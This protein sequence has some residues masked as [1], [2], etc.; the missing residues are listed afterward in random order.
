MVF[1]YKG[2]PLPFGPKLAHNIFHQIQRVKENKPCIIVVDGGLGLGKTTLA[3]EVGDFI[4]GKPIDLKYQLSMGGNDFQE[5]LQ[6]CQEQ[7]LKVLI[8]DEAGD[9]SKRSTMTR[10]NRNLERIFDT[11]RTYKIIVIMCLP[12][13]FELDRHIYSTKVVRM[14]IHLGERHKLG[15]YSVYSLADIEWMLYHYKKLPLKSAVYNAQIPCFIENFETLSPERQGDLDRLSTAAKKEILG[16]N[17][18]AARGLRSLE[19][20]AKDCG[21]TISGLKNYVRQINLIPEIVYKKKNYYSEG[22]TKTLLAA[23]Y[24]KRKHKMGIKNIS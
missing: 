12:G 18:L 16:N 22:A 1:D 2:Q 23:V 14:L 20:I 7:R 13:F 9:F 21:I 17:V 15:K 10:F 5:K 19:D 11:F 8:Y 6:I 24:D 4:E 3:V